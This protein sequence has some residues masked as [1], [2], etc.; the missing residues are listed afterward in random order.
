MA[1]DTDAAGYPTPRSFRLDTQAVDLLKKIGATYGVS[2][3]DAVRISIRFMAKH[4]GLTT[5]GPGK[6][7]KG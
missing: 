1:N 7:K 2:Q 5:D 4:L 3:A 6:T